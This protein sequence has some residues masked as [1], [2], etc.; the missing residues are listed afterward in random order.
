MSGNGLDQ[1]WDILVSMKN[2]IKIPKGRCF[3]MDGVLLMTTQSPDQSW[4]Q[5]CQ[6]FAPGLALAPHLLE[7]ALHESRHAY[8]REIEHDA[9]KQRRD[10]LEPFETRQEVVERALKQLGREERAL[11]AEMVRAYEALREEH[12]QLTPDALE[13]LQRLRDLALPLALLNNG[14]ATWPRF[15]ISS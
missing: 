12:R 7:D 3:D 6:Q 8:K 9:Q 15:L 5:V 14:N 11:A 1:V 2:H 13:T 10:R 4:Q